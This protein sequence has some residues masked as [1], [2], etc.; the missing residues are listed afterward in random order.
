[1]LS[2]RRV[3]PRLSDSKPTNPAAP[4]PPLTDSPGHSATPPSRRSGPFP[5]TRLPPPGPGQDIP[6]RQT[7]PSH[8]V[9][10]PTAPAM[11]RPSPTSPVVSS[12]TVSTG[13]FA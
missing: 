1:P 2:P 8:L 3:T 13:P 5:A 4:D 9:A 7:E 11:T 6:R 12:R 10:V